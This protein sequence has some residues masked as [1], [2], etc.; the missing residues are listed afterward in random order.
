MSFQPHNP[1]LQAS[2]KLFEAEFRR[3]SAA[4]TLIAGA[5]GT[6]ETAALSKKMSG[7]RFVA[8]KEGS[9]TLRTPQTS[10]HLASEKV[11]WARCSQTLRHLIGVM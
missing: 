2:K 8:E 10:T 9:E 1:W 6:T 5:A 4:E 3:R 11:S 7:R